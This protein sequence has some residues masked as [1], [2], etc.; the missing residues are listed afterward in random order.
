MSEKLETRGGKRTGAGRP[1]GQLAKRG[2]GIRSRLP[3]AYREK[4]K[5]SKILNRLIDFAEGKPGA[6]M[7]AHQVTAALG[8]LRKVLPDLS[9]QSTETYLRQEIEMNVK[10]TS[11]VDDLIGRINSIATRH[12]EGG[13]DTPDTEH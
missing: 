13:D 5:N 12:G 3:E 8:L 4:V 9:A 7:S 11:N 2:Q 6:D 10:V 1:K